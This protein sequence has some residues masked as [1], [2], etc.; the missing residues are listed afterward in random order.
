MLEETG[1]V[2][3]DFQEFSYYVFDDGK[4]LF[5]CFLYTTDCDKNSIKLQKGETIP[6]KW[7]SENEFIE[8]VNT[9]KMIDTQKRR[10]INGSKKKDI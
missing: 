10:Y 4:S 9:D 6:F 8:F 7:I 1:I 3:D 2:C 5:H